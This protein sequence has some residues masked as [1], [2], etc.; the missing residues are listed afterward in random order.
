[1][2]RLAWTVVFVVACA[3]PTR[4][5]PPAAPPD[6]EYRRAMTE[7]R[8]SVAESERLSRWVNYALLAAVGGLV[9]FLV[10]VLRGEAAARRRRGEEL[11]QLD[12][13]NQEFMER[14]E[15]QTRRMVELL[16]SIDWQFRERGHAEPGAAADGG[17]R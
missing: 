16:E 7:Y 12:R 11:A 4:G 3:A 17:A 14:A 5:Q 9:A 15:A 13:R 6:D 1:M 2:I 10:W 8:Q